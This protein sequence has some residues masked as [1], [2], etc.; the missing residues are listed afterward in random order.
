MPSHDERRA[1][2]LRLLPNALTVLRVAL[3]AAFPFVP[4]SW[5][6]AL[7]GA[8]LAT[9]YLDGAL[10]RRFGWTSRFGRVLD[11]IADRCLFVAV[12]A[13]LLVDGA[14]TVWQL[15]ALGAR[16]L[17]V[18]AGGLWFAAR[19][20]SRM[21]SKMHPRFAGKLTTALQYVALFWALLASGV[22]DLMLAATLAVGL[23]AAAQYLAD[24]YR[25]RSA[26][27]P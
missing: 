25:L 12:V 8:A 4:A 24:F 11:P 5:R 14:L 27:Q 10:A 19:G 7:L 18:V 2:A 13:T 6:L 22:P 16:D 21:L 15:A 3:A 23:L 17:L 20:Q 9:E 26:A 1:R